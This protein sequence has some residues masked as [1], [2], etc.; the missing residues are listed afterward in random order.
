M[1]LLA[2]A[3][4][5]TSSSLNSSAGKGQVQ[6][7]MTSGTGPTVNAVRSTGLSS[8]R[9]GAGLAAVGASD[10]GPSISALKS[11]NV[12]FS[13]IQARAAD[14]TWVDVLISLPATVDMVAIRDGK[15]VQLPAGFLLPGTYDRLMVT[16]TQVEIVLADDTLIAITPPAGG[17]TVEIPAKPFEIVEGQPTAV[18]LK[19]REDMS[20]Q[21]LGGSIEFEPEFECED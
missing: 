19:F 20:F 21:F 10:D 12:T 11:A 17:W 7:A 9:T 14:G 18:H 16:I 4:S 5:G 1:G 8:T 3:C 13:R 6:I 15:T 2:M